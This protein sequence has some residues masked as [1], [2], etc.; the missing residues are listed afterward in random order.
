MKISRFVNTIKFKL[1]LWISLLLIISTMGTFYFVNASISSYY[2]AFPVQNRLMPINRTVDDELIQT[3]NDD[4]NALQDKVFLTSLLAVTVQIVICS[5]GSYLLIKQMIDPLE[6]VNRLIKEINGKLLYKR[7]DIAGQSEEMNELI[8]SFNEMMDRLNVAFTGQKQFVENV[9]HEIKTPLTIIKTNLESISYQKDISKEEMKEAVSAAIGSIKFLNNLVDNLLLLS[10]LNDQKIKTEKIN[11]IA[12][13]KSVVS[14]VDKLAVQRNIK[15]ETK[16]G[17][18]DVMVSG[19]EILL[20]R[21]ISNIIENAVK[22]SKEGS[23]VDVRTIEDTKKIKIMVTNYGNVI[24]DDYKDKIFER[25]F[26]ADKSRSRLT[27]GSGLGLS[28]AKEITNIFKGDIT[29]STDKDSNTFT[30]TLP[31]TKS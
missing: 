3:I 17:K 26:R 23:R 11:A 12:L 7:V 28:I 14:D 2:N 1:I 24:P 13:V 30:I 15:I 19:N 4:R 9:S 22:Y 10:F 27:G 29:L 16:L 5:I 20:K 6:E 18:D 31:I 21:S 8:C 25:F